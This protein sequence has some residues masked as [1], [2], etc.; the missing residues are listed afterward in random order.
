MQLYTRERAR[1]N[2]Q[3]PLAFKLPG[4]EGAL[5]E[6]GAEGALRKPPVSEVPAGWFFLQCLNSWTVRV[7]HARPPRADPGSLSSP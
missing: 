4:P 3:A 7:G 5:A 2:L 6:K 1:R